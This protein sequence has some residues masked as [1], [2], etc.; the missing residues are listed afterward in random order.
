MSR[1]HILRIYESHNYSKHMC[2]LIHDLACRNYFCEEY[3]EDVADVEGE[4]AGMEVVMERSCE[5]TH[6]L[7]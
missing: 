4:D 5:L 3:E 2:G 7:S 6:L 1:C